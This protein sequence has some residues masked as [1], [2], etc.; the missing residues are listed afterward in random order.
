MALISRIDQ[1]MCSI[2]FAQSL[3]ISINI[4]AYIATNNKGG[5]Q[6]QPVERGSNHIYFADANGLFMRSAISGGETPLF[7]I[8]S[9]DG[10]PILQEK[11]YADASYYLPFIDFAGIES[12]GAWSLHPYEKLEEIAVF[13]KVY[14]EDLFIEIFCKHYSKLTTPINIYLIDHDS[15]DRKVYEIAQKYGCQV[16]RIPRGYTDEYNMRQYCEYFQRFLLTK[17]KWV[18][19]ADIDELLIYESGLAE[20]RHKLIADNWKGVYAPEHGYEIYE[21]PDLEIELDTN[22]AIGPQRNFLHENNAY[23]KPVVASTK[24]SWGPGFHYSSNSDVKKMPKLQMLHLAHMSVEYTLTREMNRVNAKRSLGDKAA[25]IEEF[26][27]KFKMSAEI[28]KEYGIPLPTNSKESIASSYE[29]IRREDI[30]NWHRVK[31]KENHI[32]SPS[33]IR[34]AI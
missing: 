22:Q 31:L 11:I 29:D 20:L 4:K 8:V 14:N 30:K 33:W 18:I 3:D 28:L 21:N 24:T 9:D 12:F 10:L 19:Y 6:I 34:S 32:I 7:V 1:Q 5:Y 23:A 2:N 15:D 27:Q 25:N 16:I 26:D 13:T 17:Y